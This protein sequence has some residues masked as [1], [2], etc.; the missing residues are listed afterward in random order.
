MGEKNILA[1]I[2]VTTGMGTVLSGTMPWGLQGLLVGSF[3]H[4]TLHFRLIS[5]SG[6][7]VILH[8]DGLCFTV[9]IS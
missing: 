8:D 7:P 4:R 6:E 2:D 9:V 1:R 5:S 3:A